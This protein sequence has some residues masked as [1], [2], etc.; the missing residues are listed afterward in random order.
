MLHVSI[1]IYIYTVLAMIKVYTDL[2]TNTPLGLT[3][4]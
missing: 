2:F 3:V 1:A 4:L